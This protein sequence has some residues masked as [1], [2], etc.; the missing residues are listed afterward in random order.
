[1]KLGPR[2]SAALCIAVHPFLHQPQWIRNDDEST[3][4]FAPLA[5]HLLVARA[6]KAVVTGDPGVRYLLRR[7]G[8]LRRNIPSGS[9]TPSAPLPGPRAPR[10]PCRWQPARSHVLT[11]GNRARVRRTDGSHFGERTLRTVAYRHRYY[12]VPPIAHWSRGSAGWMPNSVCLDV[13]VAPGGKAGQEKPE[14]KCTCA[15]ITQRARTC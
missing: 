7:Q 6:Q 9:D 14:G 1:M 15:S 5:K 2:A 3:F 10:R 13:F 4:S 8:L 12:A 11:A